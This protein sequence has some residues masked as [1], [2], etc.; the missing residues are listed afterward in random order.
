MNPSPPIEIVT[1][2]EH[3]EA[4]VLR[5][6]NQKLLEGERLI[7]VRDALYREAEAGDH[8]LIL[9]L[10]AVEY[11]DSAAL[12]WL[13]T[14]RKKLMQRGRAFQ[15]PCRRRG[16]FPFFPDQAAALEAIRQG[17]SDPLLLCGVRTELMEVFQVC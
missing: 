7:A 10:T 14:L 4:I 13:I 3:A 2:Q 6:G 1:R 16:L 11:L 17:E 5:I 12:G 15:P 9:D 8:P